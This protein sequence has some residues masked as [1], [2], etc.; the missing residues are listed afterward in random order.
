MITQNNNTLDAL[1]A[2]PLGTIHPINLWDNDRGFDFTTMS[3]DHTH[4]LY[5]S[6]FR[7]EKHPGTA[8]CEVFDLGGAKHINM[9]SLP[10]EVIFDNG[11]DYLWVDHTPEMDI[12][13]M[14]F[15]DLFVGGNK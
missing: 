3:E 4:Y 8:V 12:P 5:R 1:D 7:A 10:D 15:P 14:H 13:K 11:E 6:I 2:S 9:F